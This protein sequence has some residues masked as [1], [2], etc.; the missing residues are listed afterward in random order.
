MSGIAESIGKTLLF[1]ALGSLGTGLLGLFWTVDPFWRGFWLMS[2]SWGLVD[3]IIG[4]LA[5]GKKPSAEKARR[6]FGLNAWLDGGYLFLGVVFLFQKV[7]L[8]RGF[9]LAILIQG[10]FLLCFDLVHAQGNGKPDSVVRQ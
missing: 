7:A 9:G 2:G 1:W 5:L 10:A 4:L 3:G 6:I 8:H